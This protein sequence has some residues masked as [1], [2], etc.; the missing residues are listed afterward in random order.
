MI[1]RIEKL[2]KSFGALMAVDNV[3]LEI[4]EGE[5]SSIIGPNGAGKSTLFNLIT[6]HITCDFGKVIF[7]GEDITGLPPYHICKKGI[8]RSFQ[9]VNI[10]P[11]FT[12]F[13]NI[14]IAI[15]GGTGKSLNFLRSAR[16]AVINETVRI[17]EKIGLEQKAN[18]IG[19]QLSYG[20]QKLLELGIALA[21]DP[22]LVLLDEPTAGM[23]PEETEATMKLIRNLA[24]NIGL[25]MLFVEH[26]MKA[27][28]GFSDKIW[29]MNYGTMI[30]SGTPKEISENK[31]VQSTYL[32]KEVA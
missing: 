16:K 19:A 6:G 22:S 7:K 21:N 25:S 32:G 15:L 8:G 2:T 11:G 3:T 18:T 28:F 30:A 1:I 12:A 4:T 17:L 29:V 20:D 24:T 23:P 31:L 26:D 14:R 9:R 10:F 27:V 5:V 13:D